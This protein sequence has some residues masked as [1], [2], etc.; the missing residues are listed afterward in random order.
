VEW[1]VD[2]DIVDEAQAQKFLAEH[3]EPDLP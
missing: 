1:I 3:P 2:N